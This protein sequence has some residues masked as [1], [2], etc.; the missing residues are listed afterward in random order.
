M[1]RTLRITS[2]FAVILAV[3]LFVFPAVFGSRTDTQVEEFLNSPSVVE[4]FKKNKVNK[5]KSDEDKI[6][7]LVEQAQAF[8]LYLNP[9]KPKPRPPSPSARRPSPAPRPMGPVTA[10]F[11]L[12]GTSYYPLR[13]ELSLA[14]IDEP[15]KSLRWVRQSG[16]VGHLLIEQI[17]DGV[18]VV[19]D[20]NR[21]YELAPERPIKT[22][23][24][25]G[26]GPSVGQTGSGKP[27]SVKRAGAE[28][29]PSSIPIQPPQFDAEDMV[30]I[31]GFLRNNAGLENSE[32]FTRRTEEFFDNIMKSGRVSEEEAKNLDSLGQQLKNAEKDPNKTTTKAESLRPL[33]RTRRRRR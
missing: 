11:E 14:L 9:P 22:S 24:I 17:K 15:G 20:G 31:E 21:T 32:E 30:Q 33:N 25:K 19:K 7:P 16:K 2:I 23:L 10:K 12:L 28:K 18:V 29:R 4:N 26:E 5:T 3:V 1:T 8:A 6:S 27:A 13:P